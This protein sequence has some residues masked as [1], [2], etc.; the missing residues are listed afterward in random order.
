PR[1]E[2]LPAPPGGCPAPVPELGYAVWLQRSGIAG[3]NDGLILERLS[4]ALCARHGGAREQGR[5]G[6]GLLLDASA[7]LAERSATA[8][9]LGLRSG[10]TYRVVLAPLF[11]VWDRH[12]A[13]PEDVIS[14]RFGPLH[15]VLTAEHYEPFHANPC[16]IGSAHQVA[17]LPR[18][19]RSAL[20]ALRLSEPGSPPVSADAYGG[21]LDAIPADEDDAPHADAAAVA[22]IAE[23]SWGLETVA[24][25]VE[26]QT[27]R[28]TARALGVHHSTLQHRL[29]AITDELGFTATEGLGRA[30]LATAYLTH[31]V[32]TSRVMEAPPPEHQR[33]V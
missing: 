26:F 22:R 7:P 15:A 5:R 21:L 1:G 9:A 17:G 32:R 31:R 11:A 2:I 30:R 8:D 12:P 3:P 16:G 25:L 13:G 6:L 33:R 20:T 23:R 14:T 29:T 27:V 10:D 4:I 19:L 28:E 18:S 24:A